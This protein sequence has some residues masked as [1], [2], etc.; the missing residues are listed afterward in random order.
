MIKDVNA[1]IEKEI[2]E[3]NGSYGT[4]CTHD[5]KPVR[6]LYKDQAM[7]TV[8][9]TSQTKPPANQIVTCHCGGSSGYHEIVLEVTQ[10]G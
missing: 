2:T 5:R 8:T 1:L 4:N 9:R 7:G 3:G 6:V 10:L